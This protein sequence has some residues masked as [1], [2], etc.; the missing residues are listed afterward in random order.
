MRERLH[1]RSGAVDAGGL[2]ALGNDPA[3]WWSLRSS[4]DVTPQH[5]LDV[6]V[7]HVGALANPAVPAYT[8]VDARFAWHPDRQ[9]E[10]ALVMT[11][12]FDPHHPEWGTAAAR[13]EFERGVFLRVQWT[14]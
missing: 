12:L 7:R 9:W 2:A 14:P 13:A 5:D 1:V 6:T 3:E 8:A 10:V 11:N 4:I